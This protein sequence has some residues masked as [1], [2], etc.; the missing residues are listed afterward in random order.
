MVGDHFTCDIG[1]SFL[2]IKPSY[3]LHPLLKQWG[4]L[5]ACLV[6]GVCLTSWNQWL[7]REDLL[8]YDLG[9]QYGR[10]PD[11]IV[12]VA[13]DDNSL[14]H[15]GRWPWRRSIHAALLQRLRDAKVRAVALDVLFT[16]PDLVNPDDDV[17]LANAMSSGPP[18][19]LPITVDWHHQDGKLHEVLPT[20][21]LAKA[22]AGLAHVHLEI[23]KDGIARSVF[24]REGL[25]NPNRSQLALALMELL[26]QE[27]PAA[28][29]GDRPPSVSI[30][31]DAWVRDYHVLIPYLGPPG[32]FQH[33]SYIDVLTGKAAVSQLQNKLVLIGATAQ[34]L[35]DAYPTPRSG[36]GIA[37][38]GVEISANVLNA[39][40]THHVIRQ[41]PKWWSISVALAILFA[42]FAGF[43]W[44][45]PR[46]ALG[47]IIGLL[48]MTLLCSLLSLRYLYWWWSP[49]TALA[50][51]VLAY[52]LWS[53]R[54]LEAT[55]VYLDQELAQLEH[56]PI[57]AMLAR[58]MRKST[59]ALQVSDVLQ[60]RIDRARDATAR[61]RSVRRLL[62]EIIDAIPD[63]MLLLDHEGRIMMANRTAATLFGVPRTQNLEGT[64]IN[65]YLGH[66]LSAQRTS[67][68]S[69]VAG[70]PATVELQ[71][72][73]GRDLM[74]RVATFQNSDGDTAGAILDIADVSLI[75]NSE[76]ERDDTIRFLSHD[77]R[78]PYSSLL[79]L[80]SLLR[81]P[82]RAPPPQDAARSIESL[83]SRS[84]ALT[85]GFI[86]VARA[87]TIAP[88]RFDPT[89][90]R[91]VVQDAIDE[92]WAIAEAKQISLEV[93]IPGTAAEI[94]GNRQMLSRA[95]INLIGN[96][97]KY[98]PSSSSVAVTLELRDSSWIIKV[99]DQGPG[100]A[101]E[102]HHELFQRFR[103]AVHYGAADPG[104]IG[105]GLA[106]VRIVAEKH[107]GRVTVE[108]DIECGATFSL[109]IPAATS[110]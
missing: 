109:A 45:S 57:P 28:L 103:R 13:I 55:Q 73:D 48:T 77:L 29:P 106:F 42:G 96:A 65:D 87:H 41:M 79:G 76:R 69:V 1:H 66:M 54:R 61:L 56:E 36:E 67:Y 82:L 37:M 19:I 83:A 60:S 26:P 18:T 88:Q 110:R 30:S 108:S 23:D 44:L 62:A 34:G 68:Q 93:T 20:D 105:L 72:P 22:A 53:W 89:D 32:H 95:L 50:A 71:H 102:R 99:R 90:L 2:V 59:A 8:L 58:P 64:P 4:W 3:Q 104:G 33:V 46:R 86:A 78:S 7:W 38:S 35:G 51:M 94:A 80:A 74:L 91:D 81:D 11:D 14:K 84:L 6:I 101:P 40:R 12:I 10:A 17:L 27:K 98:S 92:V 39:L 49:A 15:I 5:L 43:L 63:A 52:P 75:K 100:V 47:L 70:A 25:G 85:D 31:S 24:L 21:P 9:L 97:I 16:E 107:N